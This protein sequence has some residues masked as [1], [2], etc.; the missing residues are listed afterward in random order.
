MDEET[1]LGSLPNAFHSKAYILLPPHLFV[2]QDLFSFYL[3]F[4][5]L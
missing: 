4:Y 2:K 5:S 1:E 3:Y